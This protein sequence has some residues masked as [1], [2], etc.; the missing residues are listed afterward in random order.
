[1]WVGAS[2]LHS[3]EGSSRS[4]ISGARCGFAGACFACVRQRGA[5][6]M[7]I[8]RFKQGCC[9]QGDGRDGPCGEAES[10]WGHADCLY[11]ARHPG[12]EHCRA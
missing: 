4:A 6:G 12:F 11:A 8:L 5:I 1:M 10:L 9:A 3:L 2:G 7:S